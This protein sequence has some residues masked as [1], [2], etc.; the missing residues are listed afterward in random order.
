MSIEQNLIACIGEFKKQYINYHNSLPNFMSLLVWPSL[1]FFQTYYMYKSFDI[2]AME[3]FGIFGHNNFIIFLITGSLVYNCFWSMVQSA[4]FMVF[5]RQNGT[6]EVV[7]ITP[8]NKVLLMYSRALGGLLSSIWMF[9]S[10]AFIIIVMSSSISAKTLFL[11]TIAF[12]I[13]LISST[14]WGGFINSLFLITRDSNYLFT[15]CDTPMSLFSGTVIP[16]Q[17][18]PFLGKAI[19][20]IFPA[21]YCLYIIR[22]IFLPYKMNYIILFMFLLSLVSLIVA[23]TIIMNLAEK[24]NKK[25]GSLSLY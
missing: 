2:T 20:S 14:I 12:F 11:I 10:F 22:G 16:I 8:A 21:T 9:G 15:I 23:T 24:N 17:A 1:V 5:E 19:G 7:F 3:R 13:I 4:F 18:F 25:N 6:L